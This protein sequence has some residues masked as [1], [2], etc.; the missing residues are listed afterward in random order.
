MKQK[1][2]EHKNYSIFLLLIFCFYSMGFCKLYYYIGTYTPRTVTPVYFIDQEASGWTELTPG[3]K[4]KL[5]REVTEI[6]GLCGACVL[7]EATKSYNC[8][9]YALNVSEGGPLG[10]MGSGE[11]P[12]EE[13]KYINDGSW[14]Q[15]ENEANAEKIFYSPQVGHSANATTV[16]DVYISKWDHKPLMKHPRTCNPYAGEIVRYFS[17][18]V[19]EISNKTYANGDDVKVASHSTLTAGDNTIIAAGAKVKYVSHEAMNIQSG[20]TVQNGAQFTAETW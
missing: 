13:E 5:A 1:K 9:S 11:L 8:H 2:H 12:D 15:E 10:W 17:R 16:E 6:Y 4:E 18:W 7:A 19:R 14:I 3:E 20:F